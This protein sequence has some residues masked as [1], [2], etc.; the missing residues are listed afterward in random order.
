MSEITLVAIVEAMLQLSM[1]IMVGFNFTFGNTVIC[2]LSQSREGATAMI[3]IDKPILEPRILAVLVYQAL[4]GF[5]GFFLR[6]SIVSR[7]YFY[8]VT[9]LVTVFFN[10]PLNDKLKNAAPKE[11]SHPNPR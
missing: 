6:L 2:T 3:A 11:L 10:L 7:C 8:I 1:I 9:T 5:T 4:L